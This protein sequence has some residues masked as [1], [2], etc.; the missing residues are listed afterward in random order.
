MHAEGD[1]YLILSEDESV[2]SYIKDELKT[3]VLSDERV[4]PPKPAWGTLYIGKGKKDKLNKIDIVGFLIQKGNLKK[5]EIGLIEV[6]DFFSYVAVKR[7]KIRELLRLIRDEKIKN[8]KT[9]I[10]ECN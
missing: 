5:E 2:P 8:K 6:K 3:I 4:L 7:T 9:V 1:S 10:E